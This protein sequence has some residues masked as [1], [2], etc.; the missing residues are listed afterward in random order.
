V[1]VMPIVAGSIMAVVLAALAV[2]VLLACRRKKKA[3]RFPDPTHEL[4]G[5]CVYIATHSA[6]SLHIYLDGKSDSDM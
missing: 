2:C 5:K 4:G 6:T 3:W 1:S